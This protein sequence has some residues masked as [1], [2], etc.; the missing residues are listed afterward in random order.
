MTEHH[1]LD[2][3]EYY[4]HLDTDSFLV[5]AVEMDPISAM[6]DGEFEFGYMAELIERPGRIPPLQLL[7]STV[8]SW[9]ES[10]GQTPTPALLAR[11]EGGWYSGA[12][13]NND[14]EVAKL[15]FVRSEGFR[16]LFAA[17]DCSGGILTHRWGCPVRSLAVWALLPDSKV[18]CK[19]I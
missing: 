4:M 14:V 12:H 6:A 9:F 19:D 5:N 8:N 1:S 3:Y 10:K 11:C 18:R 7:Y 17:I 15:S 13:Y 2:R 16:S